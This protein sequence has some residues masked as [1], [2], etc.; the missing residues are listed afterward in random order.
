M[1]N[2]DPQQYLKFA[3]ERTRPSHELLSRVMLE[4]PTRVIDLGCGPGNS[5]QV[6]FKRWPKA[7]I[8]GLDSSSEMLAKAVK[9]H[10]FW[11]WIQADLD[12][13][14][15]D[16]PYDVIFSNATLQWVPNHAEFFPRLMQ[17]VV[18]GGV[19]AVQMSY[20][21]HAPSHRIFQETAEEPG[22]RAKM[23]GHIKPIFVHAPAEYYQFLEPH[24]QQIDIWVTEYLQVMPD[25]A[26]ILEWI[27]GTGLRQYLDVL[28]SDEDRK[29]LEEQCLL[30]FAE[31]YP[32][33]A[34]GNV[35]F[36]FK[37]LF[38]VATR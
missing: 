4:Q 21:L 27:K 22:W 1:P 19:L 3:K 9:D 34:N 32:P 2:W 12:T 18:P 28:S 15:A 5:T 6:L 7:D 13:W 16:K 24:A 36:P 8:T 23:D 25:A 20:N 29:R 17:Q 33:Q 26:A 37:R 35:L 30:R 38:I 31:A 10:P 14:V 11:H